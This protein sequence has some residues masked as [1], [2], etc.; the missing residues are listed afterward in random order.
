MAQLLET[1]K[2]AKRSEGEANDEDDFV[3]P[4]PVTKKVND[5]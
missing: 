2:A 3:S 4:M 1:L 5:G